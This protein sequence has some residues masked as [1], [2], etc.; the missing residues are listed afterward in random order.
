MESDGVLSTLTVSSRGDAEMAAAEP[1]PNVAESRPDVAEHRS[2]VPSRAEPDVASRAEPDVAS[3]AERESARRPVAS[4][5]ARLGARPSN[6][7]VVAR[8]FEAFSRRDLAS[9]LPLLHREIVFQPVT[10]QVTREGEPYRGHDGMR[11]YAED[12]AAHWDELTVRP[13]QI[14]AAGRAVVAIGLVSGRGAAGSFAD[15]PTTWVVKFRDGLVNHVQIFSDARMA[16]AALV[17]GDA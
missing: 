8:L 4:A 3:R 17:G 2:D 6:E 16:H 15:A 10:A 11:R 5:G 14:R 7:A 9:V 1:Q 13:A 12:V